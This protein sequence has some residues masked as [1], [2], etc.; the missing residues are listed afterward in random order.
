MGNKLPRT[1][2]KS[3]TGTR[4]P[5]FHFSPLTSHFHFSLLLSVTGHV[6]RCTNSFHQSILPRLCTPIATSFLK[7]PCPSEL[8]QSFRCTYGRVAE[9]P[10]WLPSIDYPPSTEGYWHPVTST[11]NWCEEV[12][13]TRAATSCAKHRAES[14]TTMLHITPL[15]LSIPS[16]TFCSCT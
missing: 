4:A 15:K 14:R 6:A 16:Q 9:M 8:R 2:Y 3:K 12:R 1:S 13:T 11:L 10:A 7:V 5:A